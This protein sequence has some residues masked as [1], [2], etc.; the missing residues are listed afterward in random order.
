MGKTKIVYKK[1][2][3]GDGATELD[4]E[5]CIDKYLKEEYFTFPD[6]LLSYFGPTENG[7]NGLFKIISSILVDHNNPKRY[8]RNLEIEI[9]PQHNHLPFV[10]KDEL[11]K[12]GF[13]KLK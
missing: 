9:I 1:T 7:N 13:K 4:I 12:R 5:D 6:A 10:L 2:Y 11:E 8:T 3:E